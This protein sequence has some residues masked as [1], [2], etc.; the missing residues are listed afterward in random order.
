MV[1]LDEYPTITDDAS[2]LEAILAF[3]EAMRTRDRSRQ[4]Y[5]AIL[6]QDKAGKIIG[7]I[8]QFAFLKALESKQNML[9]DMGKLAVAGVS[10]EFINMMMENMQLFNDNIFDLCRRAAHRNVKEV[11]HP[12]SEQIDENAPLGEAIKN[13]I[14]YQTLSILVTRN[15]KAVGLL[16]VSDLCQQVAVE[17]KRL[18]EQ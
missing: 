9:G 5:R 7:K 6:I 10:N 12:I 4:P 2:L 14:T 13:I 8:G 11:M 3:E 1:P 17:M 18:A 16:R 15:G